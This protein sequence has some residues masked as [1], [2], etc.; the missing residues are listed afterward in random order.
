MAL[1]PYPASWAL[2]A[3]SQSHNPQANSS[4]FGPGGYL[5]FQ[6]PLAPR[7]ISRASV[8]PPLIRGF[9][10]FLGHL[11]PP[12]AMGP[13]GQKGPSGRSS[14]PQ[15]QVGPTEPIL[16]RTLKGPK[17]PK[18]AINYHSPQGLS[19]GLLQSPEATSHLQRGF[20]LIWGKFLTQLNIPK[21]V[22]TSS[23]V[24]VVLYTIMHHFSSEI[25][26]LWSQVSIMTF[27]I[28]YP[29]HSPNLKEGFSPSV[30]QSMAATR[31]PLE[32]PN[33]LAFHVLAFSSQ[34][35]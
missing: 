4:I 27:Q 33:S 11:G 1:R 5:I 6:V 22:G 7:A 29:S 21:P 20:P 31:S 17:A 18:M 14:S 25:Q 30:L 8:S 24:Y 2:L 32:D 3:N 15:C 26:L 34:D 23:G 19:H 9:M 10:A 35:S 13:M 16:A 12:Q 28:K